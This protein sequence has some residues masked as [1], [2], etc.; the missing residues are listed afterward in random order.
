MY[1]ILTVI[2]LMH[3]QFSLVN[4]KPR[5]MKIM[6]LSF[7]IF[8]VLLAPV[9]GQ[10]IDPTSAPV[11][12]P[13]PC[14]D[15]STFRFK[16]ERDKTCEWVAEKPPERC[17]KEW[18][19][20]DLSYYC[21]RSCGLCEPSPSP[22]TPPTGAPSTPPT[23]A[24]VTAPP[25]GCDPELCFNDPDFKHKNCGKYDC[26]WVA[27]NPDSRCAKKNVYS[28]CPESCAT[29]DFCLEV[30]S[31]PGKKGCAGNNAFIC[32]V[33]CG[34]CDLCPHISSRV[35]LKPVQLSKAKGCPAPVQAPVQAPSTEAP[36]VSNEPS[37]DPTKFASEAPTTEYVL[38]D[39]NGVGCQTRDVTK[40]SVC[41]YWYCWDPIVQSLHFY[42]SLN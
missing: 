29:S 26:D 34:L 8:L 4:S 2:R 6:N 35:G 5:M 25:T 38:C 1:S 39:W 24:P 9:Y 31:K 15:D 27:K 41:K 37:E 20:I 30:A 12:P 19:Q 17:V 10:S 33:T 36:S 21:P 42:L 7:P 28:S 11:V 22:S 32:P 23:A 13:P 14:I 40:I 18:K 3:D 16:Q